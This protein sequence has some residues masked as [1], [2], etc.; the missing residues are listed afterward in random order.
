M[1]IK[2]DTVRKWSVLA[3]LAFCATLTVIVPQAEAQPTWPDGH[4]GGR[5]GMG[6]GM[7]PGLRRLDLDDAQREQIRSIM[8]Q[9]RE[10]SRELREL[11][12]S[13]RM[14]LGDA[15]TGEQVNESAIRAVAAQ[16]ATLE[17][18]AAVQRAY[19]N[20]E[21]WQ[22]LTPD[23]RVELRELKAEAAERFEERRERME[24]RRRQRG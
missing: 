12:M 22:L 7:L 11:L 6:G 3:S 8:S 13:T 15:V 14:A 5:L 1:T 24:A 18:E 4:R 19:V 10:S 20:A 2:K 17:G 23:Q 9:H 21:V 16:L